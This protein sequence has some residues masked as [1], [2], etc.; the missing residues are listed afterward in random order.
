MNNLVIIFFSL[1]TLCALFSAF[2]LSRLSTKA[3]SRRF[4]AG[5]G[6]TGLAFAI[7]S[8][9]VITKP[10]NLSSL[11]DLGLVFL[12]IGLFFYALA[13]V[14]SYSSTDQSIVG[15]VTLLF[16]LAI[17]VIRT[18]YP[19]VP[20]F[21]ANGFFFFNPDP[22]VKVLEII[23]ICVTVIPAA[24]AVA[25]DLDKKL[26]TSGKVILSSTLVL[27]ICGVILL[28]NNESTMLYWTGWVMSL[29]FLTLL[30][31]SAGLLRQK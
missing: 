30:G 23:L 12:L 24:F 11:V 1:L 8:Y 21:S 19:S 26:V 17:W 27:V 18:I 20:T 29:A 13:G 22:R 6:L 4:S 3:A 15:V 2:F 25:S 28:S 5:L 16:G 10:T 7:W 9:A 31:S 14:R